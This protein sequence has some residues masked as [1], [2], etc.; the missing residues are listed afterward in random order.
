MAQEGVVLH[1]P[2]LTAR[3]MALPVTMD[4]PNASR[5]HR[6]TIPLEGT[7]M[8][9]AVVKA[10]AAEEM[11]PLMMMTGA[12]VLIHCSRS[13]ERSATANLLPGKL[14]PLR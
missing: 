9:V 7:M 8:A 3:A 12:L 2:I 11:S 5:V 4:M 6:A 13:S 1:L 14:I 10:V